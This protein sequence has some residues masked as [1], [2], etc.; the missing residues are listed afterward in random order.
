MEF[1]FRR[2][3]QEYARAIANWRYPGI[4]AFYDAEQ[5][6]EDLRELLDSSNWEER[7]FAVVDQANDLVGFFSFEQGEGGVVTI[8]LGLKPD[9]T[10]NGLG[11]AF[12]ASGLA[13]AR[14]RFRPTTFRLSVATFNRRAIKT[15]ERAGFIPDGVFMNDTNGGR[16]E[17]LRMVRST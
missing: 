9:H 17:F 13:F 3:N 6:P 12:V 11:Q 10:G 4:Y 7:Y 1:Q 16:H 15:Y 8:G 14:E 5:D 2:M